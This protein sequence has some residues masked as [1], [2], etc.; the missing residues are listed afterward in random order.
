MAKNTKNEKLI[1]ISVCMGT[2]CTFRGG[3]HL[4]EVLSSETE[5]LKYCEFIESSCRDEICEQSR[6]SPVVYI[7][8]DCFLQARPEIIL[9]ELYKRLHFIK[10]AGV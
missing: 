10:S 2:N 8:D 5:I 9:E 4:I 3:S 6:N 7:D 1:R